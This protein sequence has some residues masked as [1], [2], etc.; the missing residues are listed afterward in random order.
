MDKLYKMIVVKKDGILSI[1]LIL[2]H[3]NQEFIDFI[4]K[5]IEMK[6]NRKIMIRDKEDPSIL[7]GFII[8]MHNMMMDC[9]MSSKLNALSRI[10]E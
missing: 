10:M 4:Q 5:D 2:K 3:K 7:G 9:S 1:D 8:K 6:L